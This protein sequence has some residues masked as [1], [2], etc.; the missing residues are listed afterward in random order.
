MLHPLVN[1]KRSK[2]GP[3]D[4]VVAFGEVHYI[5][6]VEI[7]PLGT[8]LNLDKLGSKPVLSDYCFKVFV[9]TDK[10]KKI[11]LKTGNP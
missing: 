5:A 3:G 2:I 4:Y 6:V 7:L 8:F 9:P 1:Y 11:G 10:R